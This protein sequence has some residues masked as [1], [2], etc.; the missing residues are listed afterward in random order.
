MSRVIVAFILITTILVFS[1]CGREIDKPS[2]I[3]IILDAVRADHLS[4][5][6]YNRET[7]PVLDSLGSQ[8]IIF[9]RCQAQAPWTLP[10]CG[11][12]V[13]GFTVKSHGVVTRERETFRIDPAMN[14]L[15]TI[16]SS[17][18]FSTAG[19][20]NN[21][22]LSPSIGFS[23][24]MEYYS[25]YP[26]GDGRAME[27][28][29]ESLAWLES[30]GSSSFFLM[31]HIMDPHAPYSP[32]SPFDMEYSETGISGGT[33]WMIDENDHTQIL[34]PEDR[35]HLV[36]MYDGEIRWTDMQLGR[37]FAGIREM[38]ISDSLLVIVVA[39]HGDEFLEHGGVDHGH[40]LYQE[41]LHVPLI[42]SGSGLAT[43]VVIQEPVGQIDILP[44]V[45]DYLDIDLPAPVDGVSLLTDISTGRALPSSGLRSGNLISILH[46]YRKTIGDMEEQQYRMYNLSDDPGEQIPLPLDSSDVIDL[47]SYWTTPPVFS[48]QLAEDPDEI[49]NSL[50]DLG[51]I[52]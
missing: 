25:F 44:T 48:P 9:S 47:E 30:N 27:T 28:V 14:T 37:L 17:E 10:A 36:D 7:S 22:L 13:S 39:D 33:S 12:I 42:I 16:L 45:L 31:I 4:C 11:S 2:V 41:L 20:V 51:Y 8:G 46:D 52:K 50:R 38:N 26:D 3:L 35:D 1:S 43:G 6:G 40:T 49:Q 34:N 29:D 32:P 19:I 21:P 15:A 23:D 5:Y 24:G 18:G